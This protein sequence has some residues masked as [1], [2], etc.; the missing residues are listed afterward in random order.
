MFL[1]ILKYQCSYKWTAKNANQLLDDI[2]QAMYENKEVY[3]VGN[4][5]CY[6]N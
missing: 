1:K 2:E 4:G 3:R 5:Y 6:A